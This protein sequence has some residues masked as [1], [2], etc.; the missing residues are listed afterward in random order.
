MGRVY[1]IE[2]PTSAQSFLDFVEVVNLNVFDSF[3]PHTP[4]HPTPSLPPMHPRSLSHAR[5]LTHS[6]P[7]AGLP[8]ECLALGGFYDRIQ[9]MV[10]G[11]YVLVAVVELCCVVYTFEVGS[12]RSRRLKSALLHRMARL[13]ARV[14]GGRSRDSLRD[15][16]R[17]S[18]ASSAR[19]SGASVSGSVSGS[20]GKP[21]EWRW[22]K[23]LQSA[24]MMALPSVSIISYLAFPAVSSLA[25]RAFD[26]ETFD[27]G[28]AFL[29]DDYAV[30]CHGAEHA[31]MLKARPIRP[32]GHASSG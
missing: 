22:V 27:D 29:R 2:I 26:C 30:V 21:T 28:S 5:T 25:F 23:R 13:G 20:D 19:N 17:S 10:F 32:T 14:R 4:L 7:P 16:S 1:Q 9:F 15:S 18:S 8:L 3:G 12:G 24:H 11:P 6:L 31:A